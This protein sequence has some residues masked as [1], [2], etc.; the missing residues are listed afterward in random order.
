[1]GLSEVDLPLTAA[2]GHVYRMR[3][4]EALSTPRLAVFL[5]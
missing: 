4:A 3:T 2:N 1:M 5:Q